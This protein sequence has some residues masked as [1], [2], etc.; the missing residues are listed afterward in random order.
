MHQPRLR[1]C[2]TAAAA[3]AALA[4]VPALAGCSGAAVNSDNGSATAGPLVVGF[5]TPK[6]GP[7][8]VTGE[9][10]V[11][12]F[13]LYLD[14]HGGKLGGRTAKFVVED[15]ADGKQSAANAAK[16]LIEQD[17]A[18]ILSG[19]ATADTTL[20]IQDMV[21]RAK[22]PFVG[23]GGRPSTLAPADLPYIWHT[24]WLSR[25]VGAAIA[26]YVKN[27]VDGPVYVI[28]PDYQ[29]GYDNVGGFV[30]AFKTAGGTI[31][32][33]D[34]KPSWTPWPATTNFLPYLNKVDPAKVK[35]V[36]TFYAGAPGV[37]FVQQYA[38]V[39]GG[40]VPLFAA[41][42]LT[43]ESILDAE[44]AAADGIRTSLP[45]AA[46]L[47]NPANRAFSTAFTKAYNGSPRLLN[48]TAYD[49][50][51]VIDAAVTAAGPKAT[52]AQINEQIGKLGQ[53]DSPRGPWRWSKDHSP[54]Q[55]YY[56]R[57]VKNDGRGR[58]NV[59][60]QPLATLGNN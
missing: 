31:A 48:V 47:D 51:A 12:G 9:D 53:I 5:L 2:L 57:I 15:E 18:T 26:E 35:G 30:D 52:P 16:K 42:F 34:G 54:V 38:Q 10:L 20:S 13:Q 40:K 33:D 21:A 4:A 45:Y 46:D 14:T 7:Y 1:R 22:I 19:G 56:L 17:H 37:A 29:G 32:N 58:A 50:A 59:N 55:T 44:G 36:F 25:E 39:L 41:G 24:S 11:R 49:A 28:G 23:T 8:K 43:D 27:T 60:V 6:T 3:V